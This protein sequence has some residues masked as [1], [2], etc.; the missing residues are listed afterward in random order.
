[1]MKQ[2]NNL[3]RSPLHYN[4]NKASIVR[5]ILDIVDNN[6][7]NFVEPFGGTGIVGLNSNAKNLVINDLNLDL[8]SIIKYLK[9]FEDD[10]LK[11]LLVT[12][13]KYKLSTDLIENYSIKRI[14]DGTK[15]YKNIN[16][17]GYQLLK[18]RF[19]KDKNISDLF[20]LINYSFN[21]MIRFNQEN[22]FNVPVGKSDF[23]AR[24][25]KYLIDYKTALNNKNT[26]LYSEDYRKIVK[27][28]NFSN[29][30]FYFDPPYLNGNA[31]YN[32]NW[33][34]EDEI[35]LY[36]FIDEKVESGM[37]FALSNTVFSNGKENLILKKWAKK[38]KTYNIEKKYSKTSYNKKNRYDAKEILVVGGA[39]WEQKMD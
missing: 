11:K 5:E 36:N 17:D 23:S 39:L 38:Y 1:M 8:I 33:T 15:G 37:T 29:T 28:F 2:K 18:K 25:L 22:E 14:S 35:N 10:E 19:S 9:S 21:R 34:E 26:K 31:Q 7:I 4:G 3:I 24:Q 16:K 20:L 27:K 30:F 13:K 12:I 6:W 32:A